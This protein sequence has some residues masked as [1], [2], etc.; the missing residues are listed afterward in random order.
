MSFFNLGLS[1]K[2]HVANKT[3][4]PIKV[5]VTP[6]KDF[7]AIDLAFALAQMALTGGGSAAATAAS[8]VTTV[9]NA[10]KVYEAILL[11]KKIWSKIKLAQ[12]AIDMT[13]ISD[14]EK[15]KEKLEA[16]LLKSAHTILP[17]EFKEVNTLALGDA[18][19]NVLRYSAAGFAL[20]HMTGDL[21][22]KDGK[23]TQ[24]GREVSVKDFLNT[25]QGASKL[26]NPSTFTALLDDVSNCTVF[27]ATENMDRT[28]IFNANSDSSWIVKDREII[29]PQEGKI[30]EEC[31]DPRS[32]GWQFFSNPKGSYLQP[33]ETMGVWDSLFVE[34]TNFSRPADIG[35][36][37]LGMVYG[38]DSQ[39]G[40]MGDSVIPRSLMKQNMEA[41]TTV[42][43]TVID[44]V[45]AIQRYATYVGC[46]PRILV[47][48]PDGD[49]VLYK[50][51]S[52]HPKPQWHSGTAN[53]PPGRVRMQEDGNLV[54][55]GPN[56]EI[57]W[58]LFAQ[59]PAEY[60]GSTVE[61]DTNTGH[62]AYNINAD[63][64]RRLWVAEIFAQHGRMGDMQELN[65]I[66]ELYWQSYPDVEKNGGYGR[67]SAMGAKGAFLH[68]QEHGQREGRAWY[69]LDLQKRYA[70]AYWDRYSDVA[71]DG[72]YGRSSAYGILGA[73]QHFVSHG[74][75]EG[76]Y[77]GV[78]GMSANEKQATL[79]D[80]TMNIGWFQRSALTD[81]KE[82]C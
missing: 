14:I 70:H 6:N 32:R 11:L 49:L 53:K 62:L 26:T 33:G 1:H 4:R 16:I 65:R 58:A 73:R 19:L 81:S 69:D 55:E 43:N 13:K 12:K 35:Q 44:G 8:G 31:S 80:L 64:N 47:Y 79:L 5:L 21:E 10:Q 78:E 37:D 59:M 52:G 28:S 54:I 61:L 72:G 48:Q 75:S 7:L 2:M 74:Q 36:I 22:I 45:N 67:N 63:G 34:T 40:L 51:V 57:H 3:D 27:I 25:V 20:S 82:L 23:V 60:V 50:I 18:V 46:S 42:A 76:R 56:G 39:I 9:S 66:A 77:W 68:Y 71:A 15:N 29:R 41:I 38:T 24:F 30:M 17:G